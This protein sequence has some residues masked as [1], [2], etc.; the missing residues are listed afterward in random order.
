MSV[1]PNKDQPPEF[2]NVDNVMDF[3]VEVDASNSI[4]FLHLANAHSVA[5]WAIRPYQC[6]LLF[7]LVEWNQ[8]DRGAVIHAKSVCDMWWRE[9]TEVH[10]RL[11]RSPF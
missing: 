10:L 1:V 7:A 3:L 2:Y 5:S 9:R 6:I 4:D 11:P 8:A